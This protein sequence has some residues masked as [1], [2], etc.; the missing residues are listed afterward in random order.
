MSQDTTQTTK[1][2]KTFQGVVVGDSAD[3]TIIVS[4]PRFVKH[5]KYKKFYKINKRY[6]AHD[7]QNTF[8]IG[9][10]VKIQECR[11]ISKDKSFVV[12]YPNNN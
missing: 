3:K 11:P 5:P 8:K 4:I 2:K 9:D 6:K 12:L 1:Y 10:T 7:E